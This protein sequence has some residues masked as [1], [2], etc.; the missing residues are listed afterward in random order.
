MSEYLV[1]V[2]VVNFN[3]RNFLQNCL[4]SLRGISFPLGKYEIIVVD[5][6]STDGSVNMVKEKFPQA[7]II[8]LSQNTG[9]S[10]GCNLAAEKALGDYL[11]FL[12]NDTIVD[13]N[14]LNFLY[15]AVIKSADMAAVSSKILF[16][17]KYNGQRRIQSAG[18]DIFK[19]GYARDRG[20]VVK[21][22]QQIYA[23]DKGFDEAEEIL[24]FNGGSV[25]I[26]RQVFTSL[27]G[28][29]ESYFLYYEDVDFSLRLQRAGF[30][31]FYEPKSIVFHH[32]AATSGEFSPLFIYH[33]EKNRLATLIKHFPIFVVLRES[34]AYCAWFLGSF[35]RM[36][37][38]ALNRGEK[39]NEWKMKSFIRL[40]VIAWVLL[41]L[42]TLLTKRFRLQGITKISMNVVYKKLGN[43]AG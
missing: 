39:F 15:R 22:K 18:V 8:E 20:V 29:D 14:W 24:S 31:I 16:M 30:K 17:E 32:H 26:N 43:Y 3:G 4:S 40:K 33:T 41:N 35:I 10:K 2:V 12:N 5:N 37:K 42:P 36:V 11:V 19:N 1:S 21:D 38:Y 23:I 34:V 27:G 6:N 7:K 13:K 28:F 9:F 25:I